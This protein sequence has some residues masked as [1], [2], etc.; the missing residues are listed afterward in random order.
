VS[1]PEAAVFEE[2]VIEELRPTD[3]AS[4][5]T[6]SE[7]TAAILAWLSLAAID[8]LVRLGGFQRLHQAV[9]KFPTRGR[10]P[11]SEDEIRQICIAV[12]RAAIYYF[13]HAWCLQRSATATCL[14]RLR[15]IP[16]EMVI[17]VQKM[18]FY[19]HA[20]V[21]WNGNVLNDHPIVQ[22]RYTVLERC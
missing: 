8:L 16:A 11:A 7:R 20:W 9:R 2:L 10:K 12:D 21:E 4:A 14:L 22:K 6:L 3:I 18:P 5:R 17:G 19:A 15:G 13:K 1:T